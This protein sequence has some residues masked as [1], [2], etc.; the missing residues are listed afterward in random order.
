[1]LN[2]K[3]PG[4]TNPIPTRERTKGDVLIG[5]DVW[6]GEDVFILS[7]VTIGDGCCIGAKSIVTKSLPPYT[8]CVGSPCKPIKKRFPD[9]IINLLL[10]I[11]WWNWDK[12]KIKS[13]SKFFHTNLNNTNV[14]TI[15]KI[16][17]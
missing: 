15:Q 2:S 4:I 17:R 14:N 9:D 3:H 7:G 10:K 13:N 12:S 8:I 1:M 11:Q 16:I 6:I 5:N